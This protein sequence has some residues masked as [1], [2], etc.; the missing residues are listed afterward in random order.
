MGC[1]RPVLVLCHQPCYDQVM[2]RALCVPRALCIYPLCCERHYYYAAD[3]LR[4]IQ[5]NAA[6]KYSNKHGRR[7]LGVVFARCWWWICSTSGSLAGVHGVFVYAKIMLGCSVLCVVSVRC[8]C[9]L[10]CLS[11]VHGRCANK[12]ITIAAHLHCFVCA[13]RTHLVGPHRARTRRR[14]VHSGNAY[15]GDGRAFAT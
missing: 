10:P 11:Y 7:W 8:I 2:P 1:V 14:R 12:Q 5:R 4:G 6:W 15:P 9:L 13:H 3:S